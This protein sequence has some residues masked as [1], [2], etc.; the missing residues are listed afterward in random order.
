MRLPA[1]ARTVCRSPSADFTLLFAAEV[2]GADVGQP[3]SPQLVDPVEEAMAEFA[4]LAICEQT[5]TDDEHIR[6]SRA[7]GPLEWP[8]NLGTQSLTRRLRAVHDELSDDLKA[9]VEPLQA[10]HIRRL[11][12]P[13]RSAQNHYQ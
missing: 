2:I 10:V 9:T 13:A 7:F 3:P 4:V 8:P 1:R 11:D 12:L 5:I 6:F